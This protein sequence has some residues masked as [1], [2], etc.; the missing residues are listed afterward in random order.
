ML[1]GVCNVISVSQPIRV[2]R[3]PKYTWACNHSLR[4]KYRHCKMACKNSVEKI[5][6]AM[7]VHASFHGVM[8]HH[9]KDATAKIGSWWLVACNDDVS[10]RQMELRHAVEKLREDMT[11]VFLRTDF[12]VEEDDLQITVEQRCFPKNETAKRSSWLSCGRFCFYGFFFRCVLG[13]W[14]TFV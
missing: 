5:Q 8:L 12:W 1:K 7:V 10:T 6:P 14:R 11:S 3:S 13:F 2:I 4:I 9:T